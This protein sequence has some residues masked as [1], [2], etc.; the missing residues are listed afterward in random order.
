MK[1][2]T[3]IYQ[4]MFITLIALCIFA[5]CTKDA[6]VDNSNDYLP[7]QV[8]NYWVISW[9]QNSNVSTITMS[10]D[11][12]ENLS[13]TD[14]YW[15]VQ[16]INY[17]PAHYDTAYIR[18]TVDGKVYERGKSS[19]EILK[20][21]F[22]GSVGE[23]W[24]YIKDPL[25]TLDSRFPWKVTFQ[26]KSDTVNRSTFTFENCYRYYYDQL[27]SADEEYSWCLAPGVGFVKLTG[28]VSYRLTKAK[29]NGVETVY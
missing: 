29:I 12:T 24:S 28:W 27:Q 21:D 25:D 20:F 18:K 3:L 7:L 23:N 5:S 26:S 9:V 17:P 8:G 22:S 11:K 1:N 10:I 13:G 19:S 4:M 2:K 6:V 15:L 16:T 14:Y